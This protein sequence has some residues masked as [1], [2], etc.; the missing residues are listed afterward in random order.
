MQTSPHDFA[1]GPPSDFD[2]LASLAFAS[3][4]GAPR[5]AYRSEIGLGL[6]FSRFALRVSGFTRFPPFGGLMQTSPHGF[7]AGPPSDF[8]AL[9]SLAVASR[10]GAPRR[11]YRSSS[12]LASILVACGNCESQFAVSPPF[13]RRRAEEE[14]RIESSLLLSFSPS[15]K[16]RRPN[17]QRG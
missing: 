7:A 17:V 14:R 5:R 11:A 9:A 8:D 12:R 1:A 4:R 6:R 10:R 16:N 15:G 2:A 3:R 13:H